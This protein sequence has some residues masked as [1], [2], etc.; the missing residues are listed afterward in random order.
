MALY[1]ALAISA[2]DAG[3]ARLGCVEILAEARDAAIADGA[4]KMP[5]DVSAVLTEWDIPG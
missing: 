2:T 5:E 1:A 4:C 3:E